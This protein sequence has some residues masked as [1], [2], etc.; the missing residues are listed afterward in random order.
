MT[1]AFLEEAR[2]L[3]LLVH[4]ATPPIAPHSPVY[5]YVHYAHVTTWF[6]AQEGKKVLGTQVF[7]TDFIWQGR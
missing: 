7:L 5:M 4:L 3:I 6:F 2:T 1:T